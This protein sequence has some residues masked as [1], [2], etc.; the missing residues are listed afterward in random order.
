MSGVDLD[1]Y[2]YTISELLGILELEDPTSEEIIYETNEYI[3][4]FSPSNENRPDLV[5][6]FQ[7]MQT[8]LLSYM[9]ELENGENN[10]YNAEDEQTEEWT[11]NQALPQDD[12]VQTDK[13]T[14]RVQKID[15]YDNNHM[16]ISAI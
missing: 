8:K 12:P 4:R 9:N 2:N 1:V 5:V 6:F 11:T 10:E 7:E 16:P 3:T 14:G 15:V 13:I